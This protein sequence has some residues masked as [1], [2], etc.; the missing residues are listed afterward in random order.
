MAKDRWLRPRRP[1]DLIPRAGAPVTPPTA[2]S[3]VGTGIPPRSDVLQINPIIGPAGGMSGEQLEEISRQWQ[4]GFHGSPV[5]ETEMGV[6]DRFPKQS[7]LDELTDLGDTGTHWAATPKVPN[8][9]ATGRLSYKPLNPDE[10]APRVYPAK[11]PSNLKKIDQRIYDPE[12]REAYENLY[13]AEEIFPDPPLEYKLPHAMEA[14]ER[15]IRRDMSQTVFENNRDIFVDMVSKMR[16][17]NRAVAGK[18]FD[19]IKRGEAPDT[20]DIPE[21]SR[22]SA[23]PRQDPREVLSAEHLQASSAPPA[24]TQDIFGEKRITIGDYIENWGVPPSWKARVVNEYRRIL[25]EQGY[26]GIEYE[27][28]AHQEVRGLSEE[29]RRSF[30]IFNPIEETEPL[31]GEKWAKGGFIDKPLYDRAV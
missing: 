26:S 28:T 24:L 1:G 9:F 18:I 12:F 11:I 6:E 31:F 14:D 10:D 2:T 25:Q 17:I 16:R 29:D 22:F 15:A 5:G 30:V 13:A 23:R 21:N 8:R 27:N 19:M 3:P 20:E 4:P 7:V